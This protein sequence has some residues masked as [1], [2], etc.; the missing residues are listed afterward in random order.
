MNLLNGNL[1]VCTFVIMKELKAHAFNTKEKRENTV[2]V[3]EEF[4]IQL[5]R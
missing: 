5:I 1:K 2:W 4:L 3:L